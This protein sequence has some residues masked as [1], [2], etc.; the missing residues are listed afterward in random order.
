M[1]LFPQAFLFSI[2]AAFFTPSAFPSEMAAQIAKQVT[3][4]IEGATQGSG[5]VVEKSGNEYTVL[6]AWHVLSSNKSG[7]EISI[8]TFDG[9]NHITN[10]NAVRRIPKVDLAEI[11][12]ISR[13]DYAI[14]KKGDAYTIKSGANI[15]VA[16]FPLPTTAVPASIYRFYA[17]T[18]IANAIGS[19]IPS[20]YELLYDNPTL[21]GMSGG[22]VINADG[23][24]IGIHGRGETDI[25][26]TEQSGVAVKTGT[27][28]AIP[29]VYWK[30]NGI[31]SSFKIPN[32]VDSLLA[33][34]IYLFDK[35]GPTTGG[36]GG[37][38]Y[39]FNGYEK[40]VIEL[41]SEILDIE[42]NNY[43]A[44][45]IRGEALIRKPSELASKYAIIS[46]KYEKSNYD[47][48]LMDEYLSARNKFL[49]VQSKGSKTNQIEGLALGLSD[50]KLAEFFQPNYIPVL[51]A[52][53]GTYRAVGS[54]D[55][56]YSYWTKLVDIDNKYLYDRYL[57][58]RFYIPERRSDACNDLFN[59]VGAGNSDAIITVA[60]NRAYP[61]PGFRCIENTESLNRSKMISVLN[62]LDENIK[63]WEVDHGFESALEAEEAFATIG[64]NIPYEERSKIRFYR[65]AMPYVKSRFSRGSLKYLLGQ[66][67]GVCQD[68]LSHVGWQGSI[69]Y[70]KYKFEYVKSVCGPNVYDK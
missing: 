9:Q 39:S 11:K 41:A 1:K 38:R 40:K 14:A 27:N 16:G 56:A 21:P 2:L 51:K 32:K 35:P 44:L 48:N 34:A 5:V 43:V 52:L 18:V 60:E 4:R 62:N 65:D 66:R 10:I 29:I 42:P 36:S 26:M 68:L 15:Y 8:F 20:G 13:N 22:A 69:M 23:H 53:A 19:K 46:E 57:F 3:V 59:A 6:T 45:R 31:S 24:L 30:D 54:K 63:L 17:G 67:Q 64:S 70:I 37:F 33:R 25:S 50:L 58:L 28:Q 61:L 55:N 12:F 7:E 47:N 49:E